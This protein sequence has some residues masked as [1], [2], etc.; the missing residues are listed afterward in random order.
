[1]ILIDTGPLVALIYPNDPYRTVCLETSRILGTE[2]MVTTWQCFTEAMHFLGRG[3]GHRL[4]DGLWDMRR[5]ERLE[6][7]STT[8]SE[9]DRMA[10]L[11][12]RYQDTPMDLA[13]SSLIAVA[14][15][16]SIRRVFTLDEE[17]YIYRLADGSAL[18]VVPLR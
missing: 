14:E 9:A 18:E 15:S 17:F 13:D 6:I 2:V 8:E 3:G 11:M 5:A 12:R 16:R 10:D 7:H 4:Q 1:M